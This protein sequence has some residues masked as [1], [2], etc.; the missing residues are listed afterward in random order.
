MIGV[1][2]ARARAQK[3]VA[4]DLREWAAFGG[5]EASL[6]IPLQPPT[7]RS[8]LADLPAAIAWADGWRGLEGVEWVTRRWASAGTQEVPERLT[9]HGADAIARFAGGAVAAEW[10]RMRDRARAVVSH[11][12]ARASVPDLEA[13]LRASLRTHARGLTDLPEDDFVRFLAVV[14]WVIEHP[15]SGRR[16]RELPIRGVD[17]KWVGKH[18]GIVEAFHAALT[19]RA[20][21]DLAE[22]TPPIRLR[23]L[24][25]ALRPGGLDYFAAPADELARLDFGTGL[26]VVLV[27]ENLETLLALPEWRGVVAVHG[28]GYGAHERLSPLPWI[29]DSRVVYWGDL[30]SHGFAILHQLRTR[31]PRA[32]SVLMDAATLR[33]F[34]DLWVPDPK[35]AVGTYGLLTATE[36]TALAAL[37]SS[38]N[39]LLEQ[40]RIDWQFALAALELALRSETEQFLE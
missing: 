15:V 17:S 20:S 40:E 5:A 33:A 8:V 12:V 38:G 32:E 36:E 14:D 27:L 1:T 11:F 39:P 31:F 29:A 26:R 22:P 6:V 24:D 9:L 3:R 13:R 35:P 30:D 21:L 2:E 18:R 19:G 10:G 37:R 28:S 16:P 25:P 7:E 23:V 34:E 4:R